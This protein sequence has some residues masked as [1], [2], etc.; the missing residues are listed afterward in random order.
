[1]IGISQDSLRTS[2]YR[3][4]QKLQ[5]PEGETLLGFVQQL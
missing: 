3:L 2:K 4:R 5:L 1:M